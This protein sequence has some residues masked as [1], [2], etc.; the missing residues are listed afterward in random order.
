MD[1]DYENGPA[2][3][4][5]DQRTEDLVR[6]VEQFHKWLKLKDI[7]EKDTLIKGAK[8]ARAPDNFALVGLS[9]P[10]EEAITSEDKQLP[11]QTRGLLVTIM[12]TACAAITQ[13]V[14]SALN[15]LNF[16]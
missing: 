6:G 16:A 14:F 1:I 12:V 2:I 3:P 11:W 8:I 9:V 13:F 4:L 7:I 10:E 5:S 15:L